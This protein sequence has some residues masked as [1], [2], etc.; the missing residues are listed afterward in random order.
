[1]WIKENYLQ[2][3]ILSTEQVHKEI[4]HL[5]LHPNMMLEEQNFVLEGL[6]NVNK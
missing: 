4:L 3:N 1:K 6:F 5:P 2:N